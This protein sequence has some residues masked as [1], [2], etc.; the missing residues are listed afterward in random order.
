MRRFL[1]LALAAAACS[2]P[3]RPAEF[4]LRVGVPGSLAPLAHDASGTATVYA[5]D[6]VYEG[7]LRPGPKGL[8]SRVFERWERTGPHSLRAL[9]AEGLRFSDGSPVQVEDVARSARLADLTVRGEGR[10]LEL[11]TSP[12]GPPVEASL[13][14]A[15]V[16]KPTAGGELGTGPFR[17]V[18]QGEGRLV[19]ERTLPA[20]GRIGRVEFV[21]FPTIREAFVRALKGEVNAVVDLDERQLE[22]AEGVPHLRVVRSRG[23]HALALFLSGRALAAAQR[24]EIA[25]A[26]P[27]DEIAETAQGKGCGPATGRWQAAPLRSGAPMQVA[28]GFM[29]S[30]VERAALAVRRA[31]GARGGDVIRL[32]PANGLAGLSRYELVVSGIL[33]W[34][35]IVE[36]LYWKTGAP[37][38]YTGYSNAAY[39][40]A[41]DAG[42]AERAEAE[43][44]RDPP[45][46]L[47]CRKER[48]AVVDARLGNATLGSWGMLETLPD[49]EVAP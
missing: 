31:L 19:V 7:L 48:S 11:S 30:A 10:W 33:V 6:L 2:R 20:A 25:R 43:L 17:L 32:D 49:W 39:D 14:L 37:W 13:L 26:L 41:I 38:N 47:L 44:K 18:E 22:L 16:W 9:T 15:S 29:H 3:P 28:F 46:L 4:T 40:A 35:A 8:E 1:F 12:R 24:R 5:Q 45:V 21:S 23:P 42:D 36:P 27:L 34:P